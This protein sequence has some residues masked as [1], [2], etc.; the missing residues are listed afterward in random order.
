MTVCDPSRLF[1]YVYLSKS[2]EC[3]VYWEFQHLLYVWDLIWL[4]IVELLIM[5]IHLQI[6]II[7]LAANWCNVK[8]Q[9]RKFYSSQNLKGK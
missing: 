8:F 9:F 6:F 7:Y 3:D 4:Y 2:L 1:I 5:A